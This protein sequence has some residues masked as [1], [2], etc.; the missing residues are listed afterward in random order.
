LAGWFLSGSECPFRLSQRR[1]T[2]TA[3]Q[4][5]V[6]LGAVQLIG[7]VVSMGFNDTGIGRRMIEE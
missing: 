5:T 6:E 4:K 1:A 7:D 2:R 3:A